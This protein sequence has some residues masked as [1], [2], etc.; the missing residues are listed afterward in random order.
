M[1]KIALCDV[2]LT[3]YDGKLVRAVKYM[4]NK[5]KKGLRIELCHVHSFEL[6]KKFPKVTPEYVQF[7]YEM[8]YRTEL[9][10]EDAIMV[11]RR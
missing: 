7:V 9:S 10:T 4:D 8:V 11:L 2:C 6:E 1:A 3:R 5:G